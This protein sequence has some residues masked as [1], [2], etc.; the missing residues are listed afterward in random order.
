MKLYQILLIVFICCLSSATFG[1]FTKTD[2]IQSV[3]LICEN[4]TIEIYI[5]EE[6]VSTDT[7]NYMEGFIQTFI[8]PDSSTISILC[9]AN[10]TLCINE[11]QADGLYFR[12]IKFRHHD[13]IY[14]RVTPEMKLVFDE[15]F[16][17]MEKEN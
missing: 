12:K 9:G 6:Y 16:D 1:Q 5:P 8:Y 13:M 15:A 4:D 11:D 3:N 17:M 10:A 7:F 2:S 14:E